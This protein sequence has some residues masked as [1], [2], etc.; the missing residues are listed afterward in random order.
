MQDAE[1]VVAVAAINGN[2]RVPG[3]DHLLEH[4]VPGERGGNRNHVGPR[5]HD[6]RDVGVAQ[7]DHALDHFA[8]L[9][10][11]QTFAMAFGD[12][13]ADVFFER[14]FIRGR[15]IAPATRCKATSTT[16]A[17]KCQ[18]REQELT[19]QSSG[20]AK[21][22]NGSAQSRA[23]VHGSQRLAARSRSRPAQS[24][25]QPRCW[26]PNRAARPYLPGS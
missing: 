11:Q 23:K 25:R 15:Q 4:L 12:D 19:P 9:F 20:Q 3:V 2:P 22:R 17:S 1:D 21:N 16:R 24:R 8:G 7:F 18:R 13:R 14:I 26:R 10:F 5:R 6:L